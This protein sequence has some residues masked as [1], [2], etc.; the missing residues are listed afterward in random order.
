MKIA[1]LLLAVPAVALVAAC[2]ATS[3]DNAS[4]SPKASHSRSSLAPGTLNGTQN[5]TAAAP[6]PEAGSLSLDSLDAAAGTATTAGG[7]GSAGAKAADA[8]DPTET[9]AV[10]SKGQISLTST[11][12]DQVSL[13]LGKLLDGWDGTIASDKSGADKHG[14]PDQEQIELRVP[15]RYFSDAMTQIARLGTLVD[16][17]RTSQD[18]TTQVIDNNVRVRTQKLSIARIQ[19]LLAQATTLN[20]VISIESQ[21]SDR[22]A[23]LDSLEQQQT[24][25]ADQTSQATINVYLAAPGKAVVPAHKKHHTFFSGFHSG[26]HRLGTSTAAVLTGIGAALPFGVLA[27][28]VLAPAWA[29]WRRRSTHP[30]PTVAAEA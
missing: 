13:E 21:L 11:H 5:L 4:S 7:R 20:Q 3:A 22:Q 18:V 19:A 14:K 6:Q 28:L 29:Y 16:S 17:S 27:A 26:W 25:L 12:I 9:A 8:G 30:V 10:I 24:Y 2:G 1:P 15:S 23:R